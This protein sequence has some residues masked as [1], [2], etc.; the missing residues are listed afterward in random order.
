MTN[1]YFKVVFYIESKPQPNK[2]AF[3][4]KF[5]S[6]TV[7]A[8]LSF[9]S[10]F[11]IVYSIPVSIDFKISGI[12]A[13]MI[14]VIFSDLILDRTQAKKFPMPQEMLFVTAWY[15][16]PLFLMMVPAFTG[17]HE[18]VAFEFITAT[19]ALVY[20]SAA[21]AIIGIFFWIGSRVIVPWY[22]DRKLYRKMQKGHIKTKD[23]RSPLS[24]STWLNVD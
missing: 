4:K 22:E 21:A 18:I 6:T 19:E 2:R 17:Y 7:Y 15:L 13:A 16:I 24:P 12:T 23:K 5:F 10:A 8:V 9:T 3:M 20:P 11:L 14:V 1:L